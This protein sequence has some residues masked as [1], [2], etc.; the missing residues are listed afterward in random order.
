MT[1]Y[2]TKL[3]KRTKNPKVFLSKYNHQFKYTIGKSVTA[4]YNGHTVCDL[5]AS[6]A[7]IYGYYGENKST[8][9][10][11][12]QDCLD[13]ESLNEVIIVCK[14]EDIDFQKPADGIGAMVRVKTVTPIKTIPTHSTT[15]L[16]I[17]VPLE[18]VHMPGRKLSTKE[19]NKIT[20]E[21]KNCIEGE[22]YNYSRLNLPI[23][24]K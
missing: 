1:H 10:D 15:A 14:I 24:V 11:L 23:T 16:T 2:L 5:S 20:G 6:D 7:G 4:K 19:L 22:I 17:T 3:V 12:R 18:I 21:V 8:I 9:R 13:D